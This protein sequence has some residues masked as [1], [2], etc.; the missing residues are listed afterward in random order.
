MRSGR[1]WLD[2]LFERPS[3]SIRP[4]D[5]DQTFTRVSGCPVPRI[6]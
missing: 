3:L 6:G 4:L 5:C 2:G 1:A